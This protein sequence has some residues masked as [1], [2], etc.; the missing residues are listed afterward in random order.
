MALDLELLLA[1]AP[2]DALRVTR[3]RGREPL[4]AP[5]EF[6][7]DATSALG[8]AEL[9][10]HALGAPAE[11]RLVDGDERRTIHGIVAELETVGTRRAQSE[12]L[13]HYRLRLVPRL[14]QLGQR[15]CSRIFQH[16]RV[17]EIVR[18]VLDLH[19]IPALWLLRHR[20]P[21]LEYATQYEETDLAFLQRITAEHGIF[22]YFEQPDGAL[23]GLPGVLADAVGALQGL[24]GGVGPTWA[25]PPREVVAFSDAT[26]GYAR[27]K[28]GS[29]PPWVDLLRSLLPAMQAI[30]DEVPVDAITDAVFGHAEVEH[31]RVRDDSHA[32]AHGERHV[33]W[34][35]SGRRVVRARRA[36]YHEYDPERPAAPIRSSDTAL[37]GDDLLARGLQAGAELV[38]RLARGDTARVEQTLRDEAR[39]LGRDAL[40]MGRDAL[41]GA[42]HGTRELPFEIYDHH[43]PTLFPEHPYRAQEAR[44]M[45]EAERR[46]VEVARGHSNCPYL[47]P[48]RRFHLDDHDIDGFNRDWVVTAVEHEA[49]DRT[50]IVEGERAYHNRFECVPAEVPYLQPKPRRRTVQ[51]VETA[52]VVGSD[53]T[54]VFTDEGAHV[55]VQFHWDRGG[56]E[57]FS[58]CWIRVMQQW[59]GPGF[60]A[61]FIP[62]IGTEVVVG[63][64]GGDP[65]RP[66][67]LGGLYNAQCPPPFAL[68]RHRTRS[69]WQTRST[70]ASEGRN[71]LWFEDAAGQE[72]IYCHAERDHETDVENDRTAR[73]RH[74]DRLEVAGDRSERI[75]GELVREVR[76]N[77]VERVG[78]DA[79]SHVEG[80][81][82][83]HVSGSASHSVQRDAHVRVGGAEHRRVGGAMMLEAAADVVERVGGNHTRVVGS[84][85]ARRSATL[86]VEGAI[87]ESATGTITLRADA[88]LVLA[89]G[90]TVLRLAPDKLE[91][92]SPAIALRGDGSRLRIVDGDVRLQADGN[93]QAVADK[94]LLKASGA[95][96]ALG[97]EAQIDGGRILLNSP[98][99]A[100]DEVEDR[101]API[102]VIELCDQAGEPMAGQAYRIAFPDGSELSGVLDGDGRAELELE[103]AGEITFPGVLDVEPQ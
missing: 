9:E 80:S 98:Q 42:V 91:I 47:S 71:Q 31:L 97:S 61:Q 27:L 89:C 13:I 37:D 70:P 44:R 5:Y 4:S 78:G 59:A 87:N 88:A 43:P 94:V 49:T 76:R 58:S 16:K 79:R 50:A 83:S 86:H 35:F 32:L 56:H 65:D 99:S 45:L 8:A 82:D 77:R 41:A 40:D 68:P 10:G 20:H 29:A 85:S 63:F 69:G 57:G 72:K 1:A 2:A 100:R 53:H 17:D 102:T 54:D 95:A 84:A 60:G 51:A 11:L 46:D 52:I 23:G 64:D 81:S 38:G 34:D 26:S 18:A 90:E 75:E 73:V 30:P 15:R 103:E 25:G 14:W 19:A 101:S 24:A 92:S 6:V 48:G 28:L 21:V 12:R 7:I 93:V 55:R 74:D 33:V 96:L 62:R 67:V 66:I 36:S 3:L 39:Q 22:F